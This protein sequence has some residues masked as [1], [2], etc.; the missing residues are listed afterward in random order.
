MGR[1]SFYPENIHAWIMPV[2]M[3]SVVNG[4]FI[5]MIL[6]ESGL[7]YYLDRVRP[8]QLKAVLLIFTSVGSSV[9]YFLLFRYLKSR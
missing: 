9:F 7:M 4:T 2:L 1:K 6:D 8:I 3:L 5:F